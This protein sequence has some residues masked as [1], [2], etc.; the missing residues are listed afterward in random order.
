M[1]KV[2][3]IEDELDTARP[4]KGALELHGIAADIAENGELGLK[5]FMENR[6]DYDLILLDLKMPGMQGE[7]VLQEIRKVDAYVYVVVYTNFGDF[8]D[9]KKLVNIGIDKFI[10]KGGGTG[11]NELT[12]TIIGL[13]DPL[14][15]EG[16]ETLIDYT[17]EIPHIE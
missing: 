14:T 8:S 1:Y 2:L 5:Q 9:L 13:L 10:N 7:E 16:I 11:L 6:G 17:G 3:I 15:K 4:V 12:S